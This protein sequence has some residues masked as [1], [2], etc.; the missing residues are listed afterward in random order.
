MF[1]LLNKHVVAS[2]FGISHGSRYIQLYLLTPWQDP[3]L[4]SPLANCSSVPSCLEAKAGLDNTIEL[5]TSRPASGWPERLWIVSGKSP[6][7]RREP[8]ISNYMLEVMRMNN[9]ML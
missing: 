6:R 9:K 1:K 7:N 5:V 4:A 8:A 3:L 2:S